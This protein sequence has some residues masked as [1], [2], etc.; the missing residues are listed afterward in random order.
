M[1]VGHI[2][3]R[4]TDDIHLHHLFVLSC[5]LFDLLISIFFDFVSIIRFALFVLIKFNIFELLILLNFT[6][7]INEISLNDNIFIDKLLI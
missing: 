1:I 7:E 5:L 4:V 3:H 2:F 6:F